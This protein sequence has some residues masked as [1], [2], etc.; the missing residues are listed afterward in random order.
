MIITSNANGMENMAENLLDVLADRH[1]RD[2]GSY[3]ELSA[4]SLER[5]FHELEGNKLTGEL[6]D[7]ENRKNNGG[8]I[9]QAGDN[10]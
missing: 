9:E 2:N 1:T 6:L 4:D 3:T 8:C 10:P 5:S 7:S